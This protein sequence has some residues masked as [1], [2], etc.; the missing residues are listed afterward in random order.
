MKETS[1]VTLINGSP[2]ENGTTAFALGIIAKSLNEKD[3][4]TEI[5][6]IGQMALRGCTACMGCVKTKK[7]VFGEG[8]GLNEIAEKIHNS[9]GLVV[10]SPVY[11]AGINGTLKS[12]LD[13]LFYSGTG[14]F[15]FKPAAAVVAMRR[16][17]GTA[18]LQTIN[19]YFEFAEM[20]ITPT[21][22]WS[23]IHGLNGEQAATDQEGVQMMQVIG[24]NMAYLLELKPASN[25]DIPEP[26][27]KI[28]TNYIR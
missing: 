22:Y 11:Y 27:V 13:R 1:K 19:Q 23:G 25:I 26:A 10:G 2:H 28:K 16:A 5:I 21:M 20:L 8:D 24:R 18:A 6:Q 17:G 12:F 9:D 7:C 3:I 4:N 15:R 14:R